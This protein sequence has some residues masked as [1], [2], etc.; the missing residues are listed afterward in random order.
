MSETR[1]VELPGDAELAYTGTWMRSLRDQ[2]MFKELELTGVGDEVLAEVGGMH[3][4]KVL[5]VK[6]GFTDAGVSELAALNALADL[7]LESPEITGALALPTQIKVL[8]LTGERVH[9]DCLRGLARLQ[10]LEVLR[11]TS[12]NAT[13]EGLAW[14]PL[15]VKMVYLRL[16]GLHEDALQ[17]LKQF[18]LLGTVI[19]AGTDPTPKITR[20]LAAIDALTRVEF[21]GVTAPTPETLRPLTA[22]GIKVNAALPV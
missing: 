11:L 6:G 20:T 21:L 9:D 19:L 15:T 17:T 22:A 13:G 10:N 4:L 1:S 12:S 14:L 18:P 7:E 8:S 2:P 16:T 5:K 3:W